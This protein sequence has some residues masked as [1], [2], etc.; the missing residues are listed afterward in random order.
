MRLVKVNTILVFI[1][2]LLMPALLSLGINNIPYG[3]QP[4]TDWS[5]KVFQ[6]NIIEQKF[7][8]QVNNLSA[9]G[10]SIKNPN[11][12]NTGD[13]V[14]QLLSSD[15][16][17]LRTSTLNGQHIPDGGFEQFTFMPVS[18]SL[19][20]P[21]ILE[22]SAPSSVDL[23]S[24]EIF[25]T[26]QQISAVDPAMSNGVLV[27]GSMAFVQYEHPRNKLTLLGSIYLTWINKLVGDMSFLVFYLML[28]ISLVVIIA[29]NVKLIDR[30][31]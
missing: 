2:L 12:A 13:I 28:V 5:V 14:L 26:R 18:D 10:I 3:N 9:I 15:R 29:P 19:N 11:L 4:S 25:M 27:P 31:E 24:Y 7:T 6:N 17:I 30:K 23:D 1:A 20:Q 22:L 8:A 21:Y 16:H